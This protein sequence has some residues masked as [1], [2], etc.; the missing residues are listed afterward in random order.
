VISSSKNFLFFIQ[1]KV[2]FH[3]FL[4]LPSGTFPSVLRLKFCR[5]VIVN[6]W[7]YHGR[8]FC[9][10]S[11]NLIY[12]SHIKSYR[13][14]PRSGRILNSRDTSGMSLRIARGAT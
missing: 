10:R 2:L 3:L 12:F 7:L 11:A 5:T 1:L 4:S 14:V 9:G 8:L 6:L 13:A